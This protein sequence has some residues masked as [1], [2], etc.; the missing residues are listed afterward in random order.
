MMNKENNKKEIDL[1]ELEKLIL[2]TTKD[3][4]EDFEYTEILKGKIENDN[5]EE[6]TKIYKIK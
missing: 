5:E 3:I 4:I 1:N 2:M 6:I